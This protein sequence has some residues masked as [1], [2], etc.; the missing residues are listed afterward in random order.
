M[1]IVDLDPTVLL[2]HER[3]LRADIGDLA[4]CGCARRCAYCIDAS[5]MRKLS[6]PAVVSA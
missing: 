5:S 2:P 3:N 4:D 1:S 6:V